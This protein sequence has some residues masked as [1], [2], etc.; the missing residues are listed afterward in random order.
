MSDANNNL[1]L[2]AMFTQQRLQVLSLG[3]H[4]GEFSN[5]YLYAW[6]NGIYP[7]FEDG[8]GSVLKMPHEHYPEQFQISREKVDELS[9]YLDD[10]WLKKEVPTFYELESKFEVNLPSSP[11]SRIDLLYI[12]RYMKLDDAFDEDFWAALLVPGQHPSEAASILQP[13]NRKSDIYF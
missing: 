7:F 2:E 6:H 1:L 4:H 12:C 11:W 5:H 9:K 3:V 13:F 10:C 8:D